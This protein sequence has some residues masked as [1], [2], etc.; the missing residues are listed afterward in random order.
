[1]VGLMST[2][3]KSAPAVISELEAPIAVGAAGMG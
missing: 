3:V 2:S 1:M